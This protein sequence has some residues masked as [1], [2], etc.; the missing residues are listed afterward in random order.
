M[1]V[2]KMVER[3]SEEFLTIGLLMLFIIGFVVNQIIEGAV[4][5]LSKALNFK[6]WLEKQRKSIEYQFASMENKMKLHEGYN[7]YLEEEEKEARQ[8]D[9]SKF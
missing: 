8:R 7:K 5:A 9:R 1:K 6:E 2:K 4:K 3:I